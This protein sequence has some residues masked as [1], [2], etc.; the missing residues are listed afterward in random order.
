[1]QGGGGEHIYM[2]I[3]VCPF[4]ILFFHCHGAFQL[5]QHSITKVASISSGRGGLFTHVY[6]CAL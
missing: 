3:C 2:Y 4:G 1:M 6:V 5:K